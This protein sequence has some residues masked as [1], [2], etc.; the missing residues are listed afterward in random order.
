MIGLPCGERTMTI[1]Q[2]DGETDGRTNGQTD[3]QTKLLC[4]YCASVCRRATKIASRKDVRKIAF[5]HD[6]DIGLLPTPL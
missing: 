4:Q 5:G 2:R 1:P 3:R 6:V